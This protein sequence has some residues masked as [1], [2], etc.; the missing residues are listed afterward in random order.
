MNLRS[1]RR[2]TII[3]L[4]FH[5]IHWSYLVQLVLEL[6]VNLRS[7]DSSKCLYNSKYVW[8]IGIKHSLIMMF[9]LVLNK[10]C[11][12]LLPYIR[13]K[14]PLMEKIAPLLYIRHCVGDVRPNFLL[15]IKTHFLPFIPQQYGKPTSI[16]Q[17]NLYQWKWIADLLRSFCLIIISLCPSWSVS[18]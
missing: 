11:Q 16:D 5:K 2:E 3:I 6:F 13:S 15:F 18:I 10:V 1:R 12:N 4:G 8:F 14:T 17:D 7:K 9:S